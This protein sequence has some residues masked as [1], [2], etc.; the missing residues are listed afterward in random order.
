MDSNL[1]RVPRSA[2]GFS[3]LPPPL[4]DPWEATFGFFLTDSLVASE[5]CFVDESLV[6]QLEAGERTFYHS[7]LPQDEPPLRVDI[8]LGYI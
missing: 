1:L 7:H 8:A 5:G 4:F 3:T 2:S 6:E